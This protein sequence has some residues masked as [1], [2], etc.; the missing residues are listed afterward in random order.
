MYNDFYIFG[1]QIF[2]DAPGILKYAEFWYI[3][4]ALGVVALSFCF[5]IQ[6]P[7]EDE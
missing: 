6:K 5:K 4:V 2:Q 1:V 3:P 7:L